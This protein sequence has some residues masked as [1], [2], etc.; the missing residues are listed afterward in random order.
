[1]PSLQTYSWRP[2][3][4]STATPPSCFAQLELT[5]APPAP[6]PAHTA[7]DSLPPPSS[8]AS[9]SLPPTLCSHN[10]VSASHSLYSPT[11][12]ISASLS[13]GTLGLSLPVR[14]TSVLG[15][16]PAFS[17]SITGA[18]QR[19]A[20]LTLTSV[21]SL[22][23]PP[24]LSQSHSAPISHS[25][26][27]SYSRSNHFPPVP[28]SHQAERFDQ[29]AGGDQPRGY[30]QH[31]HNRNNSRVQERTK[32]TE[33]EGTKPSS[34]RDPTH[35]MRGSVDLDSDFEIEEGI[36]MVAGERS[37]GM[38]GTKKSNKLVLAP[39]VQR[40]GYYNEFGQL[41]HG[42]E[43]KQS[44]SISQA[45]SQSRSHAY[46]NSQPLQSQPASQL[47]TQ[48]F[49][50]HPRPPRAHSHLRSASY[51]HSV[52][53]QQFSLPQPLIQSYSQAEVQSQAMARSQSHTLT[54]VV[55]TNSQAHSPPAPITQPHYSASASYRRHLA[56]RQPTTQ[57][58]PTPPH[59][60]PQ[61]QSQ[62]QI[63]PR[64]PSA[65]RGHHARSRSASEAPGGNLHP[66]AS[67]AAAAA[68]AEGDVVINGIL[69]HQQH[70]GQH[71]SGNP[72]GSN[73]LNGMNGGSTSSRSVAFAPF[74]TCD[75]VGASTHPVNVSLSLSGVGSR[76]GG[77]T[78]GGGQPPGGVVSMP[79]TVARQVT[80]YLSSRQR[81]T[82]GTQPSSG[83]AASTATT[84]PE[85][86]NTARTSTL[87]SI[88]TRSTINPAIHRRSHSHGGVSG[89]KAAPLG[90]AGAGDQVV[91]G[92]GHSRHQPANSISN[93]K[94]TT[95]LVVSTSFS[96]PFN[97]TRRNWRI[98]NNFLF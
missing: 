90:S 37:S 84:N 96:S 64:Y 42:G 87:P 26:S 49:P 48:S 3:R 9:L 30:S 51:S 29:L 65:P 71:A 73:G 41:V 7:F 77:G 62:Q 19:F 57:H 86:P 67:L 85:T 16:K 54:G 75:G 55:Q 10:G 79:T 60:H 91:Q 25:Y 68:A 23:A 56:S 20:P 39:A 72:N 21:A 31:F 4:Y 34:V 13:P 88:A 40:Q 80:T 12:A 22:P 95:P 97:T 18:T 69:N 8:S 59:P 58:Q 53:Q 47:Q 28:F 46:S 24:S 70:W 66:G 76:L 11:S 44:S 94:V 83:P 17:S 63:R 52:V 38:L 98:L 27:H 36:I 89:G 43:R 45:H 82:S 1:M 81:K 2:P 5:A 6:T 74:S 33:S 78:A 14:S 93:S 50:Y 35:I 61:N 15:T 32:C 92:P